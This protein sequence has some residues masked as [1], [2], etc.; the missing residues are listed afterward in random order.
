MQCECKEL[1]DKG[2]CDKGCIWNPSNYECK[3][4]KSCDIGEYL[5]YENCKCRKKLVDKLIECSSTEECTENVEEVKI[6]KITSTELHSPENDF[7]SQRW[8]W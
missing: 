8:N 6:A 1:I 5:D 2:L 4:D 3:F 7:Y